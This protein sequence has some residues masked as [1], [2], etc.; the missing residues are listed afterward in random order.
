M[1]DPVMERLES[2]EKFRTDS[3]L[4]P[5]SR[6]EYKNNTFLRINIVDNSKEFSIIVWVGTVYGFLNQV[7]EPSAFHETALPFRGL[8]G[9]QASVCL[10]R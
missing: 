2:P 4:I 9:L 8:R 10:G 5:Y 3:R 1:V 6:L 7:I